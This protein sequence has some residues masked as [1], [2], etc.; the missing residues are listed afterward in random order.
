MVSHRRAGAPA[1]WTAIN[2]TVPRHHRHRRARVQATG[3]RGRRWAVRGSSSESILSK[4]QYRVVLV[5]K[6]TFGLGKKAVFLLCAA[7][8]LRAPVLV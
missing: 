8:R 2:S 3:R 4:L 6:A 7:P 1:C 5:T